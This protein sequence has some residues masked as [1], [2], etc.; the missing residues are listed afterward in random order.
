MIGKIRR[1]LLAASNSDILMSVTVLFKL[2]RAIAI[3]HM[4]CGLE[5]DIIDIKI[6]FYI[7]AKIVTR[8]PFT[9]LAWWQECNI[10]YT[11]NFHW[12]KI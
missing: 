3:V 6:F 8:R 11:H 2:Y 4:L 12:F 10:E 9:N 5:E 7:S 1:A